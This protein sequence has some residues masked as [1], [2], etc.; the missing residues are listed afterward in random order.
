[1]ADTPVGNCICCLICAFFFVSAKEYIIKQREREREK[2]G[3]PVCACVC[4]ITYAAIFTK[5]NHF[6]TVPDLVTVRQVSGVIK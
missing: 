1:M 5:I 3:T 4:V 6:L 2:G